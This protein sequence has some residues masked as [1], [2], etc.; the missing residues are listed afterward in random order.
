[1]CSDTKTMSKL[2]QCFADAFE[3]AHVQA[4]MPSSVQVG[5]H[6][7][8]QNVFPGVDTGYDNIAVRA[9]QDR[10]IPIC[11]CPRVNSASVAEA[12]L[13]LML[14]LARRVKEQEV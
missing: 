13:M 12:A 6:C 8:F 14:M 9:A 10:G 1:M 11:T 4:C 7:T 3:H 2:A 5:K